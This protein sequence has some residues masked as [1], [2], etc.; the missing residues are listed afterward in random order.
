MQ[1][2]LLQEARL[3]DALAKISDP[4]GDGK[5]TVLMGVAGREMHEIDPK[6]H[7]EQAKRLR[8]EAKTH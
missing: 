7:R 2:D 5:T 8:D 4:G 3:H 1:A 6:K